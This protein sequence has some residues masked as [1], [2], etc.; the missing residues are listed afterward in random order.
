MKRPRWRKIIKITKHHATTL[1]NTYF[2]HEHVRIAWHGGGV[3]NR[4]QEI[5]LLN[6]LNSYAN[7]IE[8]TSK[9]EPYLL[10]DW[11]AELSN[12]AD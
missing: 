4:K 5:A 3:L 7:I 6:T 12:F 10:D 9:V 8:R 1:M 11:I 2:H